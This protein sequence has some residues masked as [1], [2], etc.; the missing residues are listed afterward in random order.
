M[1]TRWLA[2]SVMVTVIAVT[3][4]AG[5]KAAKTAVE[6]P[7]NIA[8]PV[9]ESSKLVNPFEI[10]GKWYRA[11]LHTHT[12]LSDGDVNLPIRVKQYRDKGYQ[13]LAVTDH[14]KTNNVAGY[15]DAN[16]VLISGMETHPACPGAQIPYHFVCLNIPD[17]FKRDKAMT[18]QQVIDA[19]KAAGGEIIFAHPYWSGHTTREMLAVDG[20]VGME[21]YNGV[22]HYAGKGYN[23]VQWDQLMN[24]GKIIPAVANDDVH[25]SSAVGQS[26]TMIKAKELSTNTIMDALRSG[27]CYASCGPVIEDFRID[28][29][30]VVLKC[31]PVVEICFMGPYTLG[32]NVMSDREHLITSASYKLPPQIKWVRAEVVDAN[33]KHAWT[34]PIEIKK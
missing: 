29:N 8:A 6:K 21:V 2:I 23:S 32:N 20:Y 15:S 27:S 14:E 4:C 19:V 11:N 24:T 9:A 12:N 22:C 17:G 26:W 30:T 25:S 31:S 16:F 7:T 33:G 13:V 5:K 28:A 18:A 3:G 10:E 34:N 1:K